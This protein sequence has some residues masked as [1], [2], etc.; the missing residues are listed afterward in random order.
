MRKYWRYIG[1]WLLGFA[2]IRV[3][4][5]VPVLVLAVVLVVGLLLTATLRRPNRTGIKRAAPSGN[6]PANATD[7][8]AVML[9]VI[10]DYGKVLAKGPGLVNDVSLLPCDKDLLKKFLQTAIHLD[11]ENQ[12]L[13]GG[14]LLLSSFMEIE[15]KDKSAIALVNNMPSLKP[16]APD[17]VTDQEWAS[18]MKYADAMAVQQKYMEKQMLE[19]KSLQAELDAYL[20]S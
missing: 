20:A 2:A 1:L 3:A 4:E 5:A 17:K 7:K 16:A 8:L 18:A 14:Y 19:T 15:E 10:Q 9:R 11:R 12:M 13:L 6:P